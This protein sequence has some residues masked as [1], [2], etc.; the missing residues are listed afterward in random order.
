MVNFNKYTNKSQ[1]AIQAALSLASRYGH[2]NIEA[3]H[4]LLSMLNVENGT[5]IVSSILEKAGANSEAVKQ[6]LQ[7]ELNKLPTVSGGDEPRIS[8]ELRSALAE[9]EKFAETMGDEYTAVDHLLAGLVEK[10]KIIKGILSP[11]NI[12]SSDIINAIKEVRGVHK[13]DSQDAEQKFRALEQYTQNFTRLAREGKLDPVIGR[14]D[15][16]R[17]VIHV[18]SRRRKTIQS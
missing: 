8:G 12:K 3:S 4:L 2:P 17:R 13:V 1:E 6:Q 15:E 9:A 18:L 14:D 11:Y 7:N 16:I 5:A 10:S